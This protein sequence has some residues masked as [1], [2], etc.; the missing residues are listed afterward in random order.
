MTIKS[1]IHGGC[2]NREISR[3]LEV[4]ESTVRYHQWRQTEGATHGRAAQVLI[5]SR[6][7]AAIDANLE[8]RGETT[9][10]NVTD[11]HAWLVAEHDYPAGLRTMHRYIG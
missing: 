4:T 3:L 6:Y 11:L 10:A 1:W 2:S 9:P 7:W 5:A 8:A